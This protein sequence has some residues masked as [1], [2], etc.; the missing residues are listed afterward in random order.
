MLA[1]APL[2][3]FKTKKQPLVMYVL[4][5]CTC[6]TLEMEYQTNYIFIQFQQT[7][8]TLSAVDRV[9]GNFPSTCCELVV[10]AVSEVV[11]ITIIGAGPTESPLQ[12]SYQALYPSLL[13]IGQ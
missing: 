4:S 6:T 11:W 12:S 1:F 8:S 7:C 3:N 2:N 10:G 9:R 5:S 13:D